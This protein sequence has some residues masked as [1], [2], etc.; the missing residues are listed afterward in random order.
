MSSTS[1]TPKTPADM[2]DEN[3]KLKARVKQLTD[4]LNISLQKGME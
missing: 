4:A 3:E 2:K 1:K